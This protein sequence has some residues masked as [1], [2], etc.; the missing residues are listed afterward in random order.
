MVWR[1][2]LWICLTLCAGV[3]FAANGPPG[4]FRSSADGEA[5]F[6]VVPMDE[7]YTGFVSSLS[8]TTGSCPWLFNGMLSPSYSTSNHSMRLFALERGGPHYCIIDAIF[9]DDF[10]TVYLSTKDCDSGGYFGPCTRFAPM[11]LERSK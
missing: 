8:I 1:A 2:L 9:N 5:Y 7:P 4:Y 11:T 10:S 6:A 3:A